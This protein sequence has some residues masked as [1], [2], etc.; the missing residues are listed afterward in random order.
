MKEND[1]LR[2]DLS[3]R[4]LE[5]IRKMTRNKSP[6]AY[7]NFDGRQCGLISDSINFP[8]SGYTFCTW[9][10]IERT[11][12]TYNRIFS[13][14]DNAGNGIELL[15]KGHKM[16]LQVASGRNV[17]RAFFN[18][19]FHINR[20]YF[21]CITHTKHFIYKSE[22]KLYVDD[23]LISTNALKYPPIAKVATFAHFGTG[24]PYNKNFDNVTAFCGQCGTIALF[25]K[26]LPIE[27]ITKIFLCGPD[28]QFIFRKG[29]AYPIPFQW[30][31]AENVGSKLI[32]LYNPRAVTFDGIVLGFV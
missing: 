18:H 29:D 22:V 21:V 27:D 30:N 31:N 16:T 10:R 32:L 7:F 12:Q 23:K 14:F 3:P 6:S 15:L 13:F 4:V 26:P 9:L 28:F 19:F 1:A 2:H 11:T 8:T 20:W 17:Y 25:E 24:I 5:A